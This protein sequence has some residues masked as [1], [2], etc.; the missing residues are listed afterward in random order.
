MRSDLDKWILSHIS[1]AFPMLWSSGS[2]RSGQSAPHSIQTRV[3]QTE[4][5]SGP[6]LGH[7][8]YTSFSVWKWPGW[9][10]AFCKIEP[11]LLLSWG[12]LLVMLPF[13]LHPLVA[14]HFA[15]SLGQWISHLCPWE[16][17]LH[18][19]I[20]L[21]GYPKRKLSPLA[22][23]LSA[24]QL[25]NLCITYEITCHQNHLNYTIFLKELDP[26]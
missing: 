16:H 8:W 7:S 13:K 12:P 18:L 11:P 9:F 5:T 15:L 6:A 1:T 3:P 10:R 24:F 14:W 21:P 4:A 25:I 22:Q 17:L 2:Q 20:L 26:H 19:L 23:H